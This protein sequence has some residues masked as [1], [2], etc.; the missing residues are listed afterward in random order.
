MQ[1]ELIDYPEL[2]EM[3]LDHQEQ[4]GGNEKMKTEKLKTIDV[5]KY[6][7]TKTKIAL[8]EVIDAKHG[9]CLQVTSEDIPFKEGD[10]LPEGKCLRASKI[11]GFSKNSDDE[12]VIPLDGKGDKWLKS[13][14][15]TEAD[16]EGLEAEKGKTLLALQGVECVVQ[17]NGN[18]LELI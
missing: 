11:I 6:V 2:K 3:V 16:K 8:A 14:G 7:G 9:L 1:K 4:M 17:A 12:Y 13:K 18:F 10:S 5:L 15:V